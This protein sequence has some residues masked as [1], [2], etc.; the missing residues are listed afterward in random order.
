MACS[1]GAVV[2]RRQRVLGARG[3]DARADNGE[4]KCFTMQWFLFGRSWCAEPNAI[5]NA[6]GYA[7][8]FSHSRD[9]VIHVYDAL[10]RFSSAKKLR[11]FI[12]L[13]V[14]C[15]S[16]RARRRVFESADHCAVDRTLDPA[17]AAQELAACLKPR[18]LETV[19]RVVSVKRR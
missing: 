4:E 5:S 3:V 16:A 9:A 18:G 11:R 8:F 13:E 2:P 7:K 10:R 14:N 1:A 19:S 15:P 17:G 12:S 6:I